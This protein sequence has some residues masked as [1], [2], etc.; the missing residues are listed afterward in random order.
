MR[1]ELARAAAPAAAAAAAE[2]EQDGNV[3]TR[4]Q[5]K[6]NYFG[7]ARLAHGGQVTPRGGAEGGGGD[8]SAEPHAAA[9]A[10]PAGGHVT[11]GYAC[12]SVITGH[13][14]HVNFMV[15]AKG[16]LFSASQDQTVRVW[17]LH[18]DGFE[19][20]AEPAGHHGS[21]RPTWARSVSSRTTARA[22]YTCWSPVEGDRLALRPVW[23]FAGSGACSELRNEGWLHGCTTRQA[24]KRRNCIGYGIKST[25]PNTIV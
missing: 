5:N 19:R 7:T 9:G 20:K 2:P 22:R 10:E 8:L 13:A 15:A 24:C 12:S 14:G 1:V 21:A 18:K 11:G 17:G 3:F 23:C 4:L 25:T 16:Q 6:Q